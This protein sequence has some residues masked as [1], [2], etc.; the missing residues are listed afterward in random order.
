[1]HFCGE[2]EDAAGPE[3]NGSWRGVDRVSLGVGWD[4]VSPDEQINESLSDTISTWS[5]E[6]ERKKYLHWKDV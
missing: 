4:P 5:I 1:M 2:S 3:W 6:A